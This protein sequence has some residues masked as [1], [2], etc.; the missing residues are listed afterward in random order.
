MLYYLEAKS[1]QNVKYRGNLLFLH[2]AAFSSHDWNRTQPSILQLTAASG[3][4]SI[5]IDLPGTALIEK[6]QM[7]GSIAL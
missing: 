7:F 5:A 4:R 2:G 1:P 6:E 3:Y